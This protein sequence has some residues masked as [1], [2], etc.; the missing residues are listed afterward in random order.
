VS[1]IKIRE[2]HFLLFLENSTKFNTFLIIFSRTELL[3]S[4]VWLGLNF[5]NGR[6]EKKSE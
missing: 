3:E 1:K 6:I 4:D 5:L 2:N